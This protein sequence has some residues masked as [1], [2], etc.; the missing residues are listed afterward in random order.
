MEAPDFTGTTLRDNILALLLS[1]QQDLDLVEIVQLLI[2]NNKN[3]LLFRLID[4]DRL[5]REAKNNLILEVFRYTMQREL[6]S[7]SIRLLASY[8]TFLMTMSDFCVEA[9][10]FATQKSPR[11]FEM[12]MWILRKFIPKMKYQ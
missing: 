12:K 10:I 9:I 5:N 11:Y 8:E 1:L 2:K 4:H 6:F 7:V 3:G